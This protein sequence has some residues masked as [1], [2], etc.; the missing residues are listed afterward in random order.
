MAHRKARTLFLKTKC[1]MHFYVWLRKW[2]ISPFAGI[3]PEIN[4]NQWQGRAEQRMVLWWM[5]TTSPCCDLSPSEMTVSI[6]FIH[7]PCLEDCL[8]VTSDGPYFI[9]EAQRSLA[10]CS[11]SHSWLVTELG[12]KSWIISKSSVHSTVSHCETLMLITVSA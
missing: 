11:S 2:L 5:V 1:F 10:V 7:L 8:W 3:S 4:I 9:F 12:L 6:T